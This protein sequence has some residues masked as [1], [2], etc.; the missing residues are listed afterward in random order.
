[1][2]ETRGRRNKPAAQS[3]AEVEPVLGSVGTSTA[4]IGAGLLEHGLDTGDTVY[5]WANKLSPRDVNGKLR[6]GFRLVKFADVEDRLRDNG[7]PTT[8]YT[9]DGEGNLC[10]GVDLIL[11]QG[12]RSFQEDLIRRALYDQRSLV[13]DA[14]VSE[15]QH[16]VDDLMSTQ[17]GLPKNARVRVSKDDDHGTK[18]AL[19]LKE[20][21]E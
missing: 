14:S 19:S 18:Q 1:M 10:Y 6:A 4:L 8:F 15:L 5:V 20:P 7:I 21:N 2:S 9:E 11:M 13:D 12:S 16:K 3:A 17:Q